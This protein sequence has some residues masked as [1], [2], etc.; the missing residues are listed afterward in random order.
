MATVMYLRSKWIGMQMY[1][2][3]RAA[4]IKETA[5]GSMGMESRDT[6]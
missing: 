1:F 6:Y 4:G 3:E 5:S 2:L